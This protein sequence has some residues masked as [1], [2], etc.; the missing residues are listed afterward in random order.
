VT[1]V[2]VTGGTGFIGRQALAPLAERGFE[3]HAVARR[4]PPAELAPLATWHRFDL[5]EYDAAEAAVAAVEPTHLLHLAW[6][7]EHGAFWTS[8]ENVR[9]VEASLRLLRAFA[10]AGGRRAVLAGTCAEYDWSFGTLVEDETPLRPATLYG[11]SKH[12]LHTVARAYAAEAGFDLAWGRVFFLYGPHEAPG[13][14]VSSVIGSLLRG[15]EART[16][17]GTQ[18]RDFLHVA[19]VA[20]AFAAVLASDVTGAVNVASGEGIELREVVKRIGAL[21]GREELLSIGALPPREGDPPQLVADAR[22]LRDEVGWRPGRTL[23][24][25]LE[26]AVSWWRSE[27]AATP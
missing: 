11:A 20:D 8:P 24:Q 9:W 25:G 27:L 13:R 23:D 7:A 17:D 3:V 18:V 15:E 26:D 6:F 5:L 10:A 12:G 21:T 19:D 22:R 1:R 4:E 16:S 2:L 14:L